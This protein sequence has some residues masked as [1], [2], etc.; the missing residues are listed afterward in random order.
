MASLDCGWGAGCRGGSLRRCACTELTFSRCARRV[1]S[2]ALG[3]ISPHYEYCRLHNQA[4]YQSQ[5]VH[6]IKL[7]LKRASSLEL[8]CPPLDKSTK[9]GERP[10]RQVLSAHRLAELMG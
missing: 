3:S 8:L 10:N 1:L 7:M 9:R 6:F 4:L 5:V 2:C